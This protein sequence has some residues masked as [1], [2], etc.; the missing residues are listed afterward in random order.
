MVFFSKNARGI[1]IER[2]DNHSLFFHLYSI[3]KSTLTQKVYLARVGFWL[4]TILALGF[5]SK[6]E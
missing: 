3:E 6:I 2:D 4:G 5:E 1:K